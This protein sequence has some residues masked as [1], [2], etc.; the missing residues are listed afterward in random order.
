MHL[1]QCWISALFLP[2]PARDLWG[3]WRVIDWL[4]VLLPWREVEK[5]GGGM[6]LVEMSSD[7]L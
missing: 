1:W 5:G 4:R 6:W 7:V 2:L 3:R